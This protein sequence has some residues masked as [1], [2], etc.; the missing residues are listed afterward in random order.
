MFIHKSPIVA[1]ECA[2][3]IEDVEFLDKIFKYF[4]NPKQFGLWSKVLEN[5]MFNTGDI[6]VNLETSKTDLENRNF[7]GFG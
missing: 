6:I 4:D 1:R 2:R 5:L 3:L 7:T